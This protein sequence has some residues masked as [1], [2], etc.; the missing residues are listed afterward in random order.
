[1]SIY[2]HELTISEL[3]LQALAAGRSVR[4]ASDKDMLVDL[5]F[6]GEQPPAAQSGVAQCPVTD[7][8]IEDLRRVGGT[9]I[10]PA[11]SSYTF[12]LVLA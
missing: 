6:T 10:A 7:D 11:D 4:V 2:R 1:M 12:S 8:M 5:Y 3:G 9:G